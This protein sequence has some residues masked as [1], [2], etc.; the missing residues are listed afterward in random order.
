MA[1]KKWKLGDLEFDSEREYLDAT[2]DLKK[3]KQIMA[4]HDVTKP[5][6]ARAVL[7]EIAGKPV[8]ASSYGMKFVEKLEKTAE[9]A[10]KPAQRP[11]QQAAPAPQQTSAQTQRAG[12][13]QAEQPKAKAAAAKTQRAAAEKKKPE[14]KAKR[15]GA[16]PAKKVHIITRRNIVIGAVLIV[17]LVAVQFVLPDLLPRFSGTQNAETEDGRRNLVLAYAKNQVELQN[18]FY[19]YY[20]NV[21]GEESEAAMASANRQLASAYCVNL[22]DASVSDYS[23]DQIEEIYTK[24]TTAGELV[25]SSFNEPQAITELK[26]TIAAAGAAGA[27]GSDQTDRTEDDTAA[28]A[29]VNLFN[30]MMDYQ[31]RVAAQ[32]TYNYS[33]FSFSEEQ[34]EKYVAEDMALTFGQVVYE[35]KLSDAE[36]ETYYT[37]FEEDGLIRGGSL[38]RFSTNPLEHNLPDLT[39]TIQIHLS[40]KKLTLGCTQQTLAPVASVAY[41]LHEGKESGYLILRRN[42]T[43]GG[44][45]QD[46]DGN[47]VTTQ[48]DFL[49]NWDGEISEG[50]WYYNSTQLG[51][52]V[53]GEKAGNIQYVYDLMYN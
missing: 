15:T 45:V 32:L 14:K 8:F 22:A 10:A 19:N 38:V 3:I 53:N 29:K 48:G 43:G 16:K 47:S 24:L 40:E 34:I 1:E 37:T 50:E 25:N 36:K 5:A 49:L 52:L 35:L 6:G 44:Y 9:G 46:D 20:K 28:D 26:E 23:D 21:L 17:L 4:R 33:Q 2:K 41:E 18:S 42:G 39:P 51:L 12:A 27:P 7:N 31:Q 13:P 30:K 11:V